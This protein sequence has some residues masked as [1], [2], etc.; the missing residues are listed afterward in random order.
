M[1]S[2]E[3]TCLGKKVNDITSA[4]FH[5]I[6][7]NRCYGKFRYD[8]EQAYSIGTLGYEEISCDFIDFTY[9]CVSSNEL[10]R[11]VNR[12]I[13][14]FT[15]ALR[16]AS[17]RSQASTSPSSPPS[18]SS[19]FIDPYSPIPSP[20]SEDVGFLTSAA[21]SGT[22]FLEFLTKSSRSTWSFSEPLV[23]EVWSLKFNCL[24]EDT[25]EDA[26]NK[27]A[28]DEQLFDKVLSIVQI[29]NNAQYLPT[30]PSL[31]EV[32]SVFDTNYP[33]AQPYNFKISYKI[34]SGVTKDASARPGLERNS[35]QA[36]IKNF[37]KQKLAL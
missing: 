36:Q 31:S 14:T 26:F 13:K 16:T 4:L 11:S 2:F 19:T 35:A 1:T 9:I 21:S 22:I 24:K 10:V 20:S 27:T 29:V 3:F 37:I 8:S 15:E 34:G 25:N 30:M 32:D 33:N 17:F 28:I 7:F 12:D 6:I 23:W 5:S 18:F